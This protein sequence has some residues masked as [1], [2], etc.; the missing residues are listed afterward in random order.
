MKNRSLEVNICYAF[1]K[2]KAGETEVID[3]TRKQQII[4]RHVDGKSNRA[5]AQELH[6]SKD[7]VNKYV[8]EYESKLAEVLQKDPEAVP[9]ELIQDIVDRPKYDV[10][11]RAPTKV[12]PEIVEIIEFCLRENEVK[13]H[14]GRS[15]QQMKKKD[16]H[17]YLLEK[18]YSVSYSTVKRIIQGFEQSAREAFIRQEYEPGQ[19]CEFDWGEVKLNI[20][21]QG[22]RK[23]QMAVFT[24]AKSN[25]RFAKLYMV[26]D[27]AAFQDA[28]AEFF[29]YCGGIYRMMVYDNMRTAVKRFVGLN[30]KEPTDA[31]AKLSIYYGFQFRFCNIASGNE[32]GHV[33]RSV[34]YVRRKAFCK[35]DEDRFESLEAANAHLA[36]KCRELNSQQ[37]ST[38]TIPD[39]VFAEEQKNLLPARPKFSGCYLAVGKVDKYSTVMYRGVHYSVPDTLVGKRVQIRVY[40]NHLDICYEDRRVAVHTRSYVKRSWQIDI[41]HFLRTFSQKPGALGGSTALSQ[42]DQSIKALYE[43]FFTDNPKDFLEI[44]PLIRDL[45]TERVVQA[46]ERLAVLSPNDLSADKVKQ[47]CA[48]KEKPTAQETASVSASADEIT[49]RSRTSLSMY[50]ALREIQS[51]EEQGEV[52]A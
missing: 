49:Q 11:N 14:T 10:S 25:L 52:S 34:E 9:E 37:N 4:L 12:C 20:N 16:I 8:S 29:E 48:E 21:G 39:E 41:F 31:L 45:G 51:L 1:P 50:D 35:P 3:L 42:A 38:G 27:T 44:L 36:A 2:G 46:V 32:K 33:E 13:R 22:C 40:T 26:Q 47:L 18:G 15:K 19:V 17:A 7:T 24:P 43:R 30:E 28:H 6:I 5:I 23:Y